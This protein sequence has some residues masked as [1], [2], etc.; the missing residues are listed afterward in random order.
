[1]TTTRTVLTLVTKL[2]PPIILCGT[3]GTNRCWHLAVV[4]LAVLEINPLSIEQL[5]DANACTT[6]GTALGAGAGAMV[7]MA[8]ASGLVALGIHEVPHRSV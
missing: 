7:A 1:M 4:L 5:G 3:N 8:M 2:R 6:R